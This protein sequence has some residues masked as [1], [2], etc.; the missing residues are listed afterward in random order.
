MSKITAPD[1]SAPSALS[2]GAMQFGGKADEA[3]SRDLFRASRER[4][5]NMFDTAYVYNEGRSEEILGKLIQSERDRLIIATKADSK[6]GNSAASITESCEESRTRLGI[7]VIDLFYLHRFDDETPLEE[8]FEALAALKSDG[9][10]RHIGVSNF[11]AWQVMKAQSV[12]T[13]F[14]IR[15]DAIQPMLNIVKRQVEVELLPMCV[16]QEIDCYPYSP[17]GGGLLTGKYRAG[18]QE[19][20]LLESEIY[21]KRYGPDWMHHTAA[22]LATVARQM[23]TDPATLAVAWAMHRPGVTAPIASARSVEQLLPS[24]DALQVDWDDDLEARV[25]ALSRQPAPATDRLEE[26]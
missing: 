8:S 2:F 26:A 18:G 11:A 17:L 23:R 6:R 21:A 16:D 1:G 24:L 4:G 3:A 19:G 13:K 10:I 9:L 20:R 12:A 25:T 15:I 22:D 5:L 7:D 14:D